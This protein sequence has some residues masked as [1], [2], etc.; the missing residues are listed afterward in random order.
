MQFSS[1]FVSMLRSAQNDQTATLELRSTREP[2][3]NGCIIPRFWVDL[4]SEID[5]CFKLPYESIPPVRLSVTLCE[6][7]TCFQTWSRGGKSVK[8][9]NRSLFEEHIAAVTRDYI[10]QPRLD[11]RYLI[12]LYC[13]CNSSEL[14][15]VSMVLL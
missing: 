12:R 11:Y 14:F 1:G 3:I 4:P 2:M 8:L 10:V 6:P 9:M 5:K 15:V 13:I 7:R